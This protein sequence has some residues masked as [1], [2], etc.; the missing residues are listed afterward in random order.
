LAKVNLPTGIPLIDFSKYR[1]E[2]PVILLL[3]TRF[4]LFAI[5]LPDAAKFAEIIANA[6][7]IESTT[8]TVRITGIALLPAISVALYVIS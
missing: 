6:L 2:N 3:F 8:L 4:K 7:A 5:S 1:G